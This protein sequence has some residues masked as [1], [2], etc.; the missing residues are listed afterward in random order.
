MQYSKEYLAGLTTGVAT[1]TVY[2]DEYIHTHTLL[3]YCV[4]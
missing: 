1:S 3:Q 4:R 2:V